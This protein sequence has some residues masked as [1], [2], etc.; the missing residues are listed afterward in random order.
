MPALLK[1][2]GVSK[3]TVPSRGSAT[4]MFGS[5]PLA[6]EITGHVERV[7]TENVVGLLV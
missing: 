5:E 6:F 7:T 4:I 1:T 2:A 3:L